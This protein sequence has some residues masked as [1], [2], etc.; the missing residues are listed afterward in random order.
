MPI[1]LDVL[2]I[3][4]SITL[5]GVGIDEPLIESGLLD[6]MSMVNVLLAVE[7]KFGVTVPP[8]RAADILSTPAAL[9]AY[10]EKEGNAA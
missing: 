7:E 4:K 2:E 3:I 6:S 8:H 10:L 5:R 9:V 1:E